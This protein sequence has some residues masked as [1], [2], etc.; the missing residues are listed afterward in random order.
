MVP[1]PSYSGE[2]CAFPSHVSSSNCGTPAK[3]RMRWTPEK[4]ERFVKSVNQLGGCESMLFFV[5]HI[6]PAHKQISKF[7]I[8]FFHSRHKLKFHHHSTE[9]TPKAVLKLMNFEDMTIYHVKSHLQ[10]IIVIII[11]PKYI[12]TCLPQPFGQILTV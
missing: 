2:L 1:V 4:H 10:V 3:Q 11:L 8:I 5:C 6:C 7:R 9:A 12:K